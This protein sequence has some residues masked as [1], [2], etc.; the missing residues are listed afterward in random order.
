MVKVRME[1][2]QP[3]QQDP[4][5]PCVTVFKTGLKGLD[6]QF[7]VVSGQFESVKIWENWF[8][9]PQ[10]QTISLSK[11][12]EGMCNA[13]FAKC[14]A[15]IEAARRIDPNDP[16]GNRNIESWYDLNGLEFPAKIG[17]DKPKPGGHLHQQQYRQSADRGRRRIEKVMGG[18]EIVT[19]TPFPE[20]PNAPDA[21]KGRP[22]NRPRPLAA[23][24][25]D[26][27]RHRSRRG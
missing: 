6:C 5:D 11:G 7:T 19:D 27:K 16:N 17:V 26:K 18:G 4:Q 14:R 12:Q 9:S 3:K 24:V 10:M 8:L 25:T 20:L 1:I 23:A 21:P 22:S 15:V 2:R 13:G